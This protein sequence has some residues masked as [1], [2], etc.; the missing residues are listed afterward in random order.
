MKKAIK[1]IAIITGITAI[2]GILYML[3]VRPTLILNDYL[4]NHD[5]DDD[6]DC[7]DFI[8][9]DIE[10]DFADEYDYP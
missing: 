6:F 4:K 3:F 5:D 10:K 1:V 7:P 9:E 8:D 2:L